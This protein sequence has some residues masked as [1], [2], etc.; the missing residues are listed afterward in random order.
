MA[1]AYAEYKL[2]EEAKADLKKAFRINAALRA[3]KVDLEEKLGRL[4]K[5]LLEQKEVDAVLQH[6]KYKDLAI[7]K[8]KGFLSDIEKEVAAE[9]GK[10]KK[11]SARKEKSGTKETRTRL[12]V[13]EKKELIIQIVKDHGGDGMKLSDVKAGL[14]ARGISTPP[15][16]FLASLNLPKSAFKAAGKAKR[17]GTF[18]KVENISWLK[19]AVAE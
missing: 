14:Q 4:R 11:R 3:T 18:F 19:D 17:D 7:L 6:P 10:A 16:A 8:A 2:T 15:Q 12:S 13:D 9:Y 5:K 1:D